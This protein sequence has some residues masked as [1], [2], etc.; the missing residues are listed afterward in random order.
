MEEQRF[1]LTSPSKDRDEGVTRIGGMKE[2]SVPDKG[3]LVCP[4]GEDMIFYAL[5][6]FPIPEMKAFVLN[7]QT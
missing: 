3:S 2:N 4:L 5:L 1:S 7:D 6:M